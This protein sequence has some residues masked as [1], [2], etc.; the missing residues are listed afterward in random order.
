MSDKSSSSWEEAV[1]ALRRAAK[2]LQSAAGGLTAPTAEESQAASRLRADV[3][4][5]ERS[6]GDLMAKLSVE[7]ERQ[8]SH[9]GSS[10]NRQRVDETSSQLKESLEELA[11]LA[12]V[13]A[14]QIAAAAG[15]GLKQAEPELKA[16]VRSIEDVAGSAAAWMRA[17]VDP[18]RE[19][20]RGSHGAGQP[21]LD[22]L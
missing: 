9:V 12:V 22:D 5:L 8:R 1:E 6:A 2:E 18:V 7:L 4:Q 19:E 13:L 17:A 15:S 16:A 20:G 10:I 21:P 14:S 11:S 3:S